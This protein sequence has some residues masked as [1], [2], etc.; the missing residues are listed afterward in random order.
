MIRKIFIITVAAVIV[1]FCFFTNVF[2]QGSKP[3]AKIDTLYLPDGKPPQMAA[4]ITTSITPTSVLLS[5][6]GQA[7][8]WDGSCVP[9]E[10]LIFCQGVKNPGGAWELPLKDAQVLT[11][12]LIM[13][14]DGSQENICETWYNPRF[15]TATPLPTNTPTAT[16]TLT[17]TQE[18][19]IIPSPTSTFIPIM[20]TRTPTATPENPT[21]LEA[22]NQPRRELTCLP[23]VAGN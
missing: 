3:Q 2:A 15:P 12:A 1:L 21:G 13:W 10:N 8:D 16:E 5:S 14:P 7:I 11:C 22:I 20:P 19:T 9:S 6:N 4:W 17:P 23:W 18:P